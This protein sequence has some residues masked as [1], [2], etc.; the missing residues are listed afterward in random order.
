MISLSR[1]QVL[2]QEAGATLAQLYR[3]GE[4]NSVAYQSLKKALDT[5]L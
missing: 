5:L 1:S 4:G 2:K 3:A